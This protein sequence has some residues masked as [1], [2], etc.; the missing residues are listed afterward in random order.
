MQNKEGLLNTIIQGDTLMELRKLPSDFID[1]GITSPPYNKGEKQ[2][3]WLVKN[4][5]YDKASD[6]KNESDYQ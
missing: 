6:K 5:E 1:I 4:V 2:K 3:G